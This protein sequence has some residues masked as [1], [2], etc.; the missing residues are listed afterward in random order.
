MHM[1]ANAGVTVYWV[2]NIK[3][4]Y[5]FDRSLSD[6]KIRKYDVKDYTNLILAAG[7]AIRQSTSAAEKSILILDGFTAKHNIDQQLA[8]AYPALQERNILILTCTSYQAGLFNGDTKA[9][10]GY[11]EY[12]TADSWTLNEVKAANKRL[13][14]RN[15]DVAKEYYYTGGNM[16]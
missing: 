12:F 14:L 16:R 7:R 9:S 2:R 10:L 8:D 3:G 11:P 5:R 6:G 4:V 13:K 15:V 1:A